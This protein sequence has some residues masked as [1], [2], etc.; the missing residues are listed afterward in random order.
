MAP[1]TSDWKQFL[2]IP[3]NANCCDCG[4]SEPRWASINLGITLCIACSGVHRS[5][6][7]HHSKVRSLTLDAWEPEIV[8]VMMELGNHVVNRVYEARVDDS[9]RRA[10]ERCDDAV[11]EAWIRAKYV[12]RRFV[13]PIMMSSVGE[14]L[15]DVAESVEVRKMEAGAAEIGGGGE[16][17]AA[18]KV[19]R[20]WSVRRLRRRPNSKS[21]QVGAAADAVEQGLTAIDEDAKSSTSNVSAGSVLVIGGD[22]CDTVQLKEEMALSSDQESTG[23]EDDSVLGEISRNCNLLLS[24]IIII[25]LF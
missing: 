6:G 12:D 20:R 10:S 13:R 23:E 3:G 9:V 25:M 14:S 21:R 7:V 17:R 8:K 22:F 2:K 11:R 16:E 24:L 15:N 19:V 5:L 1:S 4:H 18:L